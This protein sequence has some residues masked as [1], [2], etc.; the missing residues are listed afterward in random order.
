SEVNSELE[1][2]LYSQLHYSSNAGEVAE[3]VDAVEEAGSQGP[4]QPEQ[5]L[6]FPFEEVIVIDSSPEV[7]SVSDDDSS[8]DDTGVCGLKGQRSEWR[9]TSTPAQQGTQKS[10]RALGTPL[11]VDSSSSESDSEES[12]SKLCSPDSSDSSDSD[13][14]E[15]WM[16]L[17][18]GNQDGDQSIS[19]NLEGKLHSNAEYLNI[20][21]RDPENWLVSNKDKEAQIYNKDKD[22]RATVHQVSN[23]YYTSKNVQCR[24]CNVYG[25]LSKNCP[26]P[27]KLVPCFLCGTHGHLATQCPNRHCNNCGLPGHLYDSCTERAYWHKVCHRCKMTGHFF[28]V[29]PE[30]WRQYH[31]TVS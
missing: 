19:L 12:E 16:I 5:A 18:R 1:F 9:Q 20:R 22:A 29:C 25:H 17:G 8:S 30:I 2:H 15:N 7:I 26:A 24:N 21:G 13:D 11:S 28:D 3:L 6:P 14:L 31:T 10:I 27:K 23:R 4:Q